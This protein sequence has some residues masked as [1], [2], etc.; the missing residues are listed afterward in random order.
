[1]RSTLIDLDVLPCVYLFLRGGNFTS[2]GTNKYVCE[3][4]QMVK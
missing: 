3:I 2:R 4:L 1:M